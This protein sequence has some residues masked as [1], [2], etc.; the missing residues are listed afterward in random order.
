MTLDAIESKLSRA[1]EA[2]AAACLLAILVLIA[3]LVL[4]RYVFNAGIVGANEASVILFVY[5]S[6]L[7]AAVEAG[8]GRHIAIAFAVDKL[9][10]AGRRWAR[11]AAFS[12]VALL[13]AWIAWLSLGWIEATGEFLMPATQLPRFAVQAAIPLGCGLATLYCL[14]A[15]RRVLAGGDPAR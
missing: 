7:G 3:A 10:P 4:L 2:V 14:L 9:G 15:V 1:I 12:L 11:A 6:A 5:A 13:N 8:R